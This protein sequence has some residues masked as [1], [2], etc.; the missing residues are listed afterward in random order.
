M[1]DLIDESLCCVTYMKFD[2]CNEVSMNL[3][4]LI[5]DGQSK[6]ITFDVK[7][8]TQIGENFNVKK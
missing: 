7:S 6:L 1:H 4:E 2:V 3:L 8:Q 5:I